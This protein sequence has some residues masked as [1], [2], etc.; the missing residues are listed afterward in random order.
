MKIKYTTALT[1]IRNIKKRIKI[2]QGGTSSSKTY[3]IL[4]I[5]IDKCTR[6]NNISISIVS[7]SF[8][9]LRKGAM[10]DFL[11]ILKES[12]RYIDKH[13]NRT[14]ST[15]TFHNGSYIEFF[16]ADGGDKLRGS[17]RNVLFINE[18]NNI[19]LDA[20]NQLS[21]RT[22]SDIYL[23]YNPSHKFWCSDVEKDD[24][25]EKIILTYKDN[26]ALSS[27]IV[28][29]LESKRL[30]A[31]TSDYWENWC[32]VYLD[33]LEG[34][35]DGVI[36]Q[37]YTVID[38]IPED[39][40]LIGYGL[41]FGYTN[42]ATALIAAYKYNDSI[43]YDEIIY[44][45][46]LLNSDI[47]SK[48]KQ[49]GVEFSS[50]IYAD[51][52]EPKSIQELKNAGYRRCLPTRKGKDSINFGIGLIQEKDI[53]ITKRSNNIKIELERYSWKK[54]KNGMTLNIPIDDYNHAI[55]AMRYII[56]I[57]YGVRKNQGTPFIIG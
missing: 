55:D 35:L 43:I 25:S 41:D 45:T 29:Y 14:N 19:T 54:D 9:H 28:N 15:Y 8:P 1:K 17:R 27:N 3:S 46:G 6:E 11:N 26:E 37:N 40:R 20:Y 30:L 32:K 48:M 57:K 18:A 24:D 56:I 4:L 31:F 50:E 49:E 13:W 10:R 47:V 21:M 5:L 34:T 52:A 2:I 51:S 22:D 53:I 12:N 36:F 16:S 7:E 38:K 42:D 23:D 33:G 39:A 44:Q